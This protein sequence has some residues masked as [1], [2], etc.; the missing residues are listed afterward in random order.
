V[1]EREL[2]R[3]ARIHE[4][5]ISDLITGTIHKPEEEQEQTP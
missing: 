1:T 3:I 5:T 2:A 4:T